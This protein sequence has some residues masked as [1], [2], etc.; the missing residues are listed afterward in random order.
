MQQKRCCQNRF[1]ICFGSI[2]S[3]IQNIMYG[4]PYHADGNT[5]CSNSS[6]CRFKIQLCSD[7]YSSL[8]HLRSIKKRQLTSLFP[9][10]NILVSQ[11]LNILY[12]RIVPVAEHISTYGLK[13]SVLKY[14]MSWTMCWSI[15]LSCCNWLYNSRFTSKSENLLSRRSDFVVIFYQ[16][17]INS[18]TI[19]FFNLFFLL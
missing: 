4:A 13:H 19:A 5:S 3:N 8:S 14:W 17:I 15:I 6:G 16:N 9:I 2:F 12:Y 10:I 18:I 11:F 7:D 1:K